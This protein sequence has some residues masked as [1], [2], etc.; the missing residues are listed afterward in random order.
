[1]GITR[2]HP[3]GGG[4]GITNLSQKKILFIHP[5]NKYLAATR[6]LT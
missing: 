1:M 6:M 3:D 4:G 5:L 2:P